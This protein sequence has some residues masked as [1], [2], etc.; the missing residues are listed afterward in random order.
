MGDWALVAAAVHEQFNLAIQS[1]Q[2]FVD[3]IKIQT[4]KL[5]A[6]SITSVLLLAWHTT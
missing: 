3:M 2:H 6:T 4:C 5:F 1:V